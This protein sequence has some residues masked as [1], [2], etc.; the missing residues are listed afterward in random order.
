MPKLRNY[1]RAYRK[2]AGFSQ[3]EL[4]FLLGCRSGSKTSRY[5]RFDREPSLKTAFAY[6]VVFSASAKELF[7]DVFHQVERKTR[8]Q[9][10]L[11][12]RRLSNGEQDRATIRK[13]A[14]LRSLISLAA[15]D[16]D[17]I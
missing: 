5:E 8:K 17:I 16:P 6:E 11:L 2:R 7:G 3:A 12:L 14:A 4:A 9:G 13:I 15:T 10:Q 1:L